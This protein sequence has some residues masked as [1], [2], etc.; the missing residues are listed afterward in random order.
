[1]KKF[2]KKFIA[3]YLIVISLMCVISLYMVF[4]AVNYSYSAGYG[5]SGKTSKYDL[6]DNIETLTIAS[7]TSTTFT[8]AKISVVNGNKTV[9]A[10]VQLEGADIRFTYDGTTPTAS[11]GQK[12]VDGSWFQIVG[13]T[14]IINFKAYGLTGT[15]TAYIVYETESEMNKTSF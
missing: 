12:V 3:K 1:M 10:V 14:N 11:I 5:Q 2:I 7:G 9:R 6:A 8:L 15:A 4:Q 13:E